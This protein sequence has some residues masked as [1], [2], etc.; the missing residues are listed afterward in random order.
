MT[1]K[2]VQSLSDQKRFKLEADITRK[3]KEWLELQPDVS[4]YKASDRFH[5]GV[6][7]FI[8]CVRGWFVGVELKRD[9]GKPS[10]HQEQFIEQVRRS[11][12]IAGVAWTLGEAKALVEEARKRTV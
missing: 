4:F 1:T 11:G 6:S 9:D 12:G 10:S 8:L 5:K 3:F 7:D 2:N